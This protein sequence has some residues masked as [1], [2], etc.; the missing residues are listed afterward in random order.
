MADAGDDQEARLPFTHA[1]PLAQLLQPPTV[2]YSLNSLLSTL[3]KC[4]RQ[5]MAQSVKRR[6][7]FKQAAAAHGQTQLHLISNKVT[8]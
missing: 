1:A 5:S 3:P 2:A 6:Q 7:T 8:K 4:Y